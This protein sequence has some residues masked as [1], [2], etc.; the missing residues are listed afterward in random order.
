M[1]RAVGSKSSASAFAEFTYRDKG[2]SVDGGDDLPFYVILNC[3]IVTDEVGPLARNAIE[4]G[5]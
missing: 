4:N 1:R 2:V 3:F 5:V